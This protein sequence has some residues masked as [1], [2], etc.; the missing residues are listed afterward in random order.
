MGTLTKWAN[1]NA[2][3]FSA[4]DVCD[5]QWLRHKQRLNHA[6]ICA[7]SQYQHIWFWSL[8]WKTLPP[9]IENFMLSRVVPI[10]VSELQLR[11]ERLAC[12]VGLQYVCLL[13]CNNFVM[14]GNNSHI[15][16]GWF[17]FLA[18][19]KWEVKVRKT[20]FFWDLNS[21]R[22]DS[23]QSVRYKIVVQSLWKCQKWSL[24][25]IVPLYIDFWWIYSTGCDFFILFVCVHPHIEEE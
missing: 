10:C 1:A 11:S 19:E 9:K 23:N 6:L 2:T 25:R 7:R 22:R 8:F 16:F 24:R 3:N 5:Q 20:R 21:A 18:T 14:M 13:G 12:R 15:S 4:W 17:F